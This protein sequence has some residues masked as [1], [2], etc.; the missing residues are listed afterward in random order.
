MSP[1]IKNPSFCVY[2]MEWVQIIPFNW[3]NNPKTCKTYV[4]R[5]FPIESVAEPFFTGLRM[6]TL[7]NLSKPLGYNIECNHMLWD[8]TLFVTHGLLMNS[9]LTCNVTQ[10]WILIT[11]LVFISYFYIS[12]ALYTD[13]HVCK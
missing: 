12:L 7:Q 2:I 5:Y 4:P 10:Y 8:A 1:H 11:A 6:R 13:I 9:H 3:F